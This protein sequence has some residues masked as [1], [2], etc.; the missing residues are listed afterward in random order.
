MPAMRSVRRVGKTSK[1]PQAKITIRANVDRD[2]TKYRK[3]SSEAA[4]KRQPTRAVGI[5]AANCSQLPWK[6]RAGFITKQKGT[7]Y[8]AEP[9]FI[10]KNPVRI[11]SEPAIAAAVIEPRATGG[12]IYD[13]HPQ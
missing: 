9:N 7:I 3:P 1:R 13:K 8:F 12:V 4:R 5:T 10:D 11:G 6:I 2:P